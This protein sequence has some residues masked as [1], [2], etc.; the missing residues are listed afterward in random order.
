MK[1][2]QGAVREQRNQDCRAEKQVTEMRGLISIGRMDT[3]HP[4]LV[5][6]SVADSF[7]HGRGL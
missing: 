5:P 1:T 6:G 4:G 7:A 2:A 3:E